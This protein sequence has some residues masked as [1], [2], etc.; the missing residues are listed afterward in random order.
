MKIFKELHRFYVELQNKLKAIEAKL[1][2]IG[3]EIN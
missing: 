3:S 2:I 1:T